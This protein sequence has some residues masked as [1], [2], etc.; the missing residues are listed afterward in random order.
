MGCND[1]EATLPWAERVREENKV[2]TTSAASNGKYFN[3]ESFLYT[4]EGCFRELEMADL[5]VLNCIVKIYCSLV[6]NGG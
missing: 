1:G 2:E 4:R 6:I 5:R 3:A